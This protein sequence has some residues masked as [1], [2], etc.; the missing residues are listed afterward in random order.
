MSVNF[1]IVVIP[2]VVVNV[3]KIERVILSHAITEKV[4]KII[5]NPAA[6]Q[7]TGGGSASPLRAAASAK[8]AGDDDK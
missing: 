7:S 3:A 2:L 8:A 1:D 5:E 6:P 4:K